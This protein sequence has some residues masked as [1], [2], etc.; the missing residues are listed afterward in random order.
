MALN[1][2]EREKEDTS[3]KRRCAKPD[4]EYGVARGIDLLGVSSTLNFDQLTFKVAR[5][6][7]FGLA[8]RTGCGRTAF[9]S[10]L[11]LSELAKHKP[12][13]GIPSTR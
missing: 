8:V 7:R 5:T 13:G 11:P 1:H 2:P 10:V 4:N 6:H 3:I 9:S 12:A